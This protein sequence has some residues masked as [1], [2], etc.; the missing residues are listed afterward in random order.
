MSFIFNII[1]LLVNESSISG[2]SEFRYEYLSE[3][4][5][6]PTNH[7][8][9][10][11]LGFLI[12]TFLIFILSYLFILFFIRRKLFKTLLITLILMTI[13]SISSTDLTP[14]L[15]AL[16]ILIIFLSSYTSIKTSM[17]ET[18]PIQENSNELIEV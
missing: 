10:Y 17:N 13:F 11:S 6:D 7:S 5:V 14:V 15:F 8:V 9:S 12:P 4:V 16:S 1:I 18:Q 2:Y 3:F